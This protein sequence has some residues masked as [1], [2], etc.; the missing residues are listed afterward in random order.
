MAG[1]RCTRAWMGMVRVLGLSATVIFGGGG[2]AGA[3]VFEVCFGNL[4]EGDDDLEVLGLSV[5]VVDCEVATPVVRSR[6]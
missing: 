5:P 4:V 1:S 3:E 6:A 2:E